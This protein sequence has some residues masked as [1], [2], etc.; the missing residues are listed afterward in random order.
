MR[1]IIYVDMDGVLV[2]FESGIKS[3][4]VEE[5]K[6]FENKLDEVPGIFSKMMPIEGA[7]E[8]FKKAAEINP[9]DVFVKE[10]LHA[11]NK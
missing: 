6:I 1:K 2:D 4:S 8:N 3:L 9:N 10:S 7:I 11:L 5:I